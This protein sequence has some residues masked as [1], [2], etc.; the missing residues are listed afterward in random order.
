MNNINIDECPEEFQNSI[1]KYLV[2]HK[3]AK[4]HLISTNTS[5]PYNDK[6]ITRTYYKAYLEW[7]NLLSV[8]YY[9]TCTKE[10]WSDS[11]V[12]EIFM[13]AGDIDVFI[14]NSFWFKNRA[15]K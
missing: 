12:S 3:G 6:S 1:Q 14:K 5:T 15:E 10:E 8:L 4:I 11:S 7:G 9:S 13:M 2:N